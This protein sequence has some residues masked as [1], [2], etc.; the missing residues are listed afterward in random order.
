MISGRNIILIG[1]GLII[2]YKIFERREKYQQRTY[3]IKKDYGEL[4]REVL[5]QEC[6]AYGYVIPKSDPK[7][8]PIRLYKCK[9][10]L[11]HST[12]K[13]KIIIDEFARYT[14]LEKYQEMGVVVGTYLK[15][16][17]GKEYQVINNNTNII[18]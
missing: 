10:G 14:P 16:D 18:I 2:L 17:N 11:P 13:Y 12:M 6:K 4:G 9:I 7:L 1:V 15:F 3:C 5:Y 8:K